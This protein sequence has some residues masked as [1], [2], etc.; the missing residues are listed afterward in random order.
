MISSVVNIKK[1]TRKYYCD[2]CICM[3]RNIISFFKFYMCYI[4]ATKVITLNEVIFSIKNDIFPLQNVERAKSDLL[5]A[6]KVLEGHLLTRTFLVTERITLA[7]IIVFS[8]LIHAFQVC[9]S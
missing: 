1:R 3:F 9:V 8:T 4:Y 5:A 6:L 7:D 2:T